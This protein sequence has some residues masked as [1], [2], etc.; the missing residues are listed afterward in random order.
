MPWIMVWLLI[1]LVFG[2]FFGLIAYVGRSDERLKRH[3]IDVKDAQETLRLSAEHEERM[4]RY[5]LAEKQLE[6]RGK[7]VD[8][9]LPAL[10]PPAT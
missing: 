9:S 1:V 4:A 3:E 5:R 10:L 8:D 7:G 6:L 2:S